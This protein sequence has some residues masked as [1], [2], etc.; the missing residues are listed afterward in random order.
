L[1]LGQPLTGYST[2]TYLNFLALGVLVQIVG[3]LAINYAQ[4]YLP[5]ST[6]APTMLG[7]PVVTA[8]LAALLLGE[9]I[10]AWHMLGGALVLVGVYAVHRSR[11]K[12]RKEEAMSYDG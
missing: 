7:Q 3:W 10:S 1:A 12:N 9:R 4:G 8:C 2:F 5:A 6:V 11:Q